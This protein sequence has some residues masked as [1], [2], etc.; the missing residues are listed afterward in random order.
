MNEARPL[1]VVIQDSATLALQLGRA[2]EALGFALQ[3]CDPSSLHLPLQ[4]EPALLC[5]EL[6]GS[7]GNGFKLLRRLAQHHACPR[8]LLTSAG[9]PTDYHWGRLAGA[10]HVLGRPFTLQQLQQCLQQT[11]AAAVAR[12]LIE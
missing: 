2:L 3:V 9:R 8:L 4:P 11:A 10:T 6:F 7:H 1:A 12:E 5:V